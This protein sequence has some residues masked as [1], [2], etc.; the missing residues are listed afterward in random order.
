MAALTAACFFGPGLVLGFVCG[1]LA[2][3]VPGDLDPAGFAAAAF[4]STLATVPAA[5]GR[6]AFTIGFGASG[7]MIGCGASLAAI[8]SGSGGAIGVVS[9]RAVSTRGASMA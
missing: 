6:F 4:A 3:L 5:S 8:R 2:D 7:H 1:A 9:I